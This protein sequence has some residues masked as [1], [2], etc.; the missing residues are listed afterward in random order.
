MATAA[1]TVKRTTKGKR[2][3]ATTTRRRATTTSRKSNSPSKLVNIL[4]PLVFIGAIL[5]CLAFLL[6]V[7]YRTVTASSFFD[8]KSIHIEGNSRVSKDEIEKIVRSETERKGIWNADLE[9][10]KGDLE[11]SAYVKT[12]VVSRV[13]PGG[14]EVRINERVPRAVVRR[15]EGD[16]WVD[17]DA[18]ILGAVGK[19][20][21]RQSFVL[22][23]WD[24]TRSEKAQKDNQERV[25]L[26]TKIQ[27][28]WQNAG[29]AK[30]VSSL[31]L[32]DMQDALATVDDSGASITI[33][34]GKDD[35]VRRLQKALEVVEGKG[36][37]IESL[38]SHGSNVIAK[39]RNS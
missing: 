5:T 1:R 28:D 30:R 20:D 16:F 8:A 24:E 36:K 33:S 25:R 35:F 12:A 15:E 34:L 29:I 4:V 39:Y 23:G 9:E 6:S 21:A 27:G 31:D 22:R 38:I 19:N 32:A 13:L 18:V 11:K 10:I 37:S 17:D 14:I 2:T 7:G 3:G 26:F